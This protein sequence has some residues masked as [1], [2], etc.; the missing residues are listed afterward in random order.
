MYTSMQDLE[1][2]K[3]RLRTF[4]SFNPTD[5]ELRQRVQ[6]YREFFMKKL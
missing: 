5:D 2:S 6:T 1:L 4:G 3:A